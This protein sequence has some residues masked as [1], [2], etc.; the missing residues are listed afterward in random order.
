MAQTDLV[1]KLRLEKYDK[2]LLLN[3]PADVHEL[4]RIDFD[5]AIDSDRLPYSLI[6]AFVFSLEQMAEAIRQVDQ[7]HLLAEDGLLDL[8]YT[9]KGNKAYPTYI[10]RDD[11]FP[12]LQVSDETGLV[13]GTPLKFN[14]MAAFS[15]TFT[16]TG[17]K[18]LGD[19]DLRA[20][21]KDR[22]S[23]SVTRFA[24]QIPLLEQ[25]LESRPEVLA[26]F[27]RL[28]PGY[29]RDWARYI[30]SAKTTETTEKRLFEAID[31]LAQGYKSRQL[32]LQ[33]RM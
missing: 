27:R 13:E 8:V 5:S 9:K 2:R 24:D 11:I 32:Y 10:G 23:Q 19:K 15:E 25:E 22:G 21:G 26:F 16:V 28:T 17:L 12:Y 31:I 1:T 20:A 30:Y 6:L 33:D 29:Q 4:D 7:D 14:S 3:R 18:R